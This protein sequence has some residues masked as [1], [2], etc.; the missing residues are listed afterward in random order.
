M[1]VP[2]HLVEYS[3]TMWLMHAGYFKSIDRWTGRPTDDEKDNDVEKV[4]ELPDSPASARAPAATEV[5]SARTGCCFCSHGGRWSSFNVHRKLDVGVAMGVLVCYFIAIG[6]V[7][8][9]SV[10]PPAI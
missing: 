1:H 9:P 2:L 3:P 5:E 10:S 4:L 8:L 6:S 7:L